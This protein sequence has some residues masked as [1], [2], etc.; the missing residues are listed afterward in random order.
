LPE[1]W[2]SKDGW[3][4]FS[5]FKNRNRRP[6]TLVLQAAIDTVSCGNLT[7]LVTAHGKPDGRLWQPHAQMVR[8]CR[9][10]RLSAQGLRKAGACIAAKNGATETQLMAIFGWS[11]PDMAA[12]YAKKARQ[13]AS[14]AMLWDCW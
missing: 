8:C 9:A 1:T 5:Q 4:H 12:L 10:Q 13:N 14:R 3:L 11:D 2:T 7:F 6:V